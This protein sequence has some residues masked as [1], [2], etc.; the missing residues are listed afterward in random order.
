MLWL[1]L[2][3]RGIPLSLILYSRGWGYKEGNRVGYNMIPIRTLSLLAYFTYISIDTSIY[4]LGNMPGLE[5]SRRWAESLRAPPW[6]IQVDAVRYLWYQSS[7]I[8]P[9]CLTHEYILGDLDL[10]CQWRSCLELNPGIKYHDMKSPSA[11]LR[12]PNA[13]SLSWSNRCTTLVH[14][15]GV[16][17][18]SQIKSFEEFNSRV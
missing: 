4:A 6:A 17:S 8:A 7:L 9:Q 10:P 15:L 14:L 13:F 2:S 11:P 12:R 18:D 3:S 16:V 1:S 5:S